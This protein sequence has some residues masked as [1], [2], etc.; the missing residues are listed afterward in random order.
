MNKFSIL[1]ITLILVGGGVYMISNIVSKKSV[2]TFCA[3]DVKVCPDGSTVSR[4]LPSCDFASCNE[5]ISE[6]A[7]GYTVTQNGISITPL[8]VVADS[9]CPV[10]VVCIQAGTASVRT[11]VR[12]KETTQEVVLSLG[13]ASFIG[14]KRIELT[15]VTPEPKQGAKIPEGDYRFVFT[16]L[17]MGTQ[18]TGSLQGVMNLGPVCPVERTDNPCKPTEEMYADKKI[19]VYAEDKK[20]R[21]AVLTPGKD[22][23]FSL[24]IAPGTYYVAM[25]TSTSGIG[26]VAG[27]PKTIVVE[28]GRAVKISVSVDTGI[29]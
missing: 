26:R 21:L 22:G 12:Y 1:L 8:E 7:I 4:V 2:Q 14:D 10:D 3:Q 13:R 9:R 23:A 6:N 20:T 11:E 5:V 17:D 19:A 24:T 18:V 15:S 27:L 28:E 29:R 16:V 25:A